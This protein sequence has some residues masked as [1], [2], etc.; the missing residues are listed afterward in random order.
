MISSYVGENATF[1]KQYLSGE[2]E[3]ELTPQGTLA[4]RIRAGGAGIPAFYTP[5]AYG[6]VIQEGGFP[7]KLNPDGTTNIGSEPREVREFNG[8]HYVM[9]RAITGD[10]AL[11]KA[12]KGDTRGN[13]VFRGTTKNFNV[14]AAKA[15]RITIAEV[16]ELVQPGEL[17]PDD[18]HVPGVFVQRIFKVSRPIWP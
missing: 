13:L 4:E 8:R 10:Y 5:T 12:W 2:L 6:T 7:I 15:G 17:N 16:E 9:E 1:E 18:I 3:V 11:V 14:D